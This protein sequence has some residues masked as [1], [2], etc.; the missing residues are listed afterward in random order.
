MDGM[1]YSR[2]AR[3]KSYSGEKPQSVRAAE[4]S[5]SASQESTIPCRFW[6]ILYVICAFGNAGRTTSRISAAN[7]L[8]A[9][10]LQAVRVSR[11]Q[12]TDERVFGDPSAP[13]LRVERDDTRLLGETTNQSV[14]DLAAS[15]GDEDNGFTHD[16]CYGAPKVRGCV[17]RRAY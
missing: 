8:H 7:W 14:A 4:S 11:S 13:R 2:N 10:T 5:T 17:W 6:S 9:P 1:R 12:G 16:R 3:S 15:A